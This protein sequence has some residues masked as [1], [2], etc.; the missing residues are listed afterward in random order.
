MRRRD[1]PRGNELG[2]AIRS[3]LNSRAYALGINFVRVNVIVTDRDRRPVLDSTEADFEV[4]LTDGETVGKSSPSTRFRSAPRHI[5]AKRPRTIFATGTKGH[6][7]SSALPGDLTVRVREP[8]LCG[9]RSRDFL[10][11]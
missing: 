3:E 2:L 1:V 10:L 8:N 9:Q 6:G 11:S 7:R 4:L 5:P